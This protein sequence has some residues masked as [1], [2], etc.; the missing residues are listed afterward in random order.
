ML[1]SITKL[2]TCS[3]L[4]INTFFSY[5]YL[6]CKYLEENMNLKYMFKLSLFLSFIYF[7]FC[8]CTLA[9]VLNSSIV[10]FPK[11]MGERSNSSLNWII[12]ISRALSQPSLILMLR[13]D[14]ILWNLRWGK[15]PKSWRHMW[16]WQPIPLCALNHWIVLWS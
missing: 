11:F 15:P 2:Q 1:W 5:L 7:F 4:K 6:K 12:C 14:S 10:C 16:F 8:N 13:L 9:N 3:V